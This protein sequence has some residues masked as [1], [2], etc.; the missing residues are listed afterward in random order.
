[1][2]TP[3]HHNAALDHDAYTAQC[4]HC[5]A[6]IAPQAVRCHHCKQWVNALSGKAFLTRFMQAVASHWPLYALLTC[7]F[8]GVTLALSAPTLGY[9]WQNCVPFAF[10]HTVRAGLWFVVSIT[11][12]YMWVRP[13]PVRADTRLFKHIGLMAVVLF[14]A[15][16]YTENWSIPHLLKTMAQD[17]EA[18]TQVHLRENYNRQDWF[19]SVSRTQAFNPKALG[20]Q[21]LTLL[22]NGHEGQFGVNPQLQHSVVFAQFLMRHQLQLPPTANTLVAGPESWTPLYLTWAWPKANGK[23]L[24]NPT[25]PI[26]NALT[27]I[28]TDAHQPT[29][30]IDGI[31]GQDV[32][33]QLNPAP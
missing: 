24:H 14:A 3:T 19:G 16:H 30:P 21:Q 6:A 13:I 4:P 28:Q 10:G 22:I 5:H 7:F 23:T 25:P 12:V 27:W 29:Q 32:L 1:M 8:Y 9:N 15:C 17:Q 2:S 26:P 31:V 18:L 20:T 33:T 11:V